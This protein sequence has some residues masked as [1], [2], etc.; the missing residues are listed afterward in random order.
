[1]D[2]LFHS[3]QQSL[4]LLPL[5]LGIYLSYGCAK[6][7]DL[8]IEGSFVLGAA[9]YAQVL[10]MTGRPLLSFLLGSIS[11]IFSGILTGCMQFK[12]RMNSLMAGI[13]TLFI[14]QSM[15]I[16]VMGRPN[17]NLLD[18]KHL[19]SDISDLTIM[20][21]GIFTIIVGFDRSLLGLKF[22]ALGSN[23]KLFG[24]RFNLDFY[25]IMILGL[26]NMLAALSGV[27]TASM[28]GYSDIYMGQGVAIIGIGTFILGRELNPNILFCFVGLMLYFGI[29]HILLSLGVDTLMMKILIGV[30]LA[31]ILG[32]R[33]V[34]CSV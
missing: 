7:T 25:R 3:A 9:T 26:S 14:L 5:V 11:G 33:R 13:I 8:T 1:M 31:I 4:L 22:K 10:T 12:N 30:F 32:G 21:L 27:L 2:L 20:G 19:I 34:K 18:Y 28:N 6:L 17:V 24:E 29:T 23:P 16:L 15:N